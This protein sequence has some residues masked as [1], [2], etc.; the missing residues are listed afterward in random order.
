MCPLIKKEA[1]TPLS[2]TSSTTAPLISPAAV[3]D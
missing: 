3:E 2:S 1:Q